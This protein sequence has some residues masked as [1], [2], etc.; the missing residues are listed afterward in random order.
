M[1]NSPAKPDRTLLAIAVVIAVLVVVAI[2]VVFTRGASPTLDPGTPEGV[3]QQYTAAVLDGDRQAAA[4]LLSPSWLETCGGMGS[5]VAAADLRI[6][7]I[8]TRIH[9]GSATVTV[10]VS[11]GY[12]GGPFGSSGY[13]Y[14]DAFQLDRD[15]AGWLIASM[16]WELSVCPGGT[17]RS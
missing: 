9:D 5:G 15:G 17:A 4:E 12:S 2:T 10:S 7:V 1:D 6:T 11:S 8:N 13:E 3:V 16:P 14:E